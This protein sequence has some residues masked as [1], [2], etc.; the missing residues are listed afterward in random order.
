MDFKCKALKKLRLNNNNLVSMDFLK[1]NFP[2][3]KEVDLSNNNIKDVPYLNLQKL[4]KLN[5][6][7]NCLSRFV[8]EEVDGT[9][10]CFPDSLLPSI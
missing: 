8:M 7:K 6:K 3:V 2:S 5:L 9:Q 10:R 4:V 1:T